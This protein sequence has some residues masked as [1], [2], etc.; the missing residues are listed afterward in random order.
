MATKTLGEIK[1]EAEARIG[2]EMTEDQF[3]EAVWYALRK[4]RMA[5]Q[6]PRYIQYMLV[7]VVSDLEYC[8]RS[9]RLYRDA[10]IDEKE[11]EA[12]IKELERASLNRRSSNLLNFGRLPTPA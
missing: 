4:A 9:M 3:R 2:R 6:P 8:E 12:W 10:Q 7:D 11:E 5:G 1:K